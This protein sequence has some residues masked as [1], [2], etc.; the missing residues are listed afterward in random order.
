MRR[1]VLLGV[2]LLL[3]PPLVRAD[4]STGA[5]EILRRMLRTDAFGWNGSEVRMRMVLATRGGETRTRVLESVSRKDGDEVRSIVRFRE[6]PDVAGTAFLLIQ[7][8]D[9]DDEQ[10]VWLPALRRTRRIVGRERQG[11]FMG[12]DFTYA[13]LDQRDFRQNVSS[14]RLSD[15]NLGQSA[16]FVLEVHPRASTSHYSKL[17]VWVR[18]ADYVPL[19][20]KFFD[21]AG[22]LEKTLYARRVSTMQGRPVIMES[23]MQNAQNGH[24]TELLLES[25]RFRNDIPVDVFTPRSLERG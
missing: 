15:E 7:H 11:S 14:R 3:A 10:Y 13:D 9:Q 8:R 2:L 12:S 18:Q 6:P 21:P 16:C 17:Q 19:R 23:R 1:I 5:G 25:I 20:I 24:S 4:S 22:T